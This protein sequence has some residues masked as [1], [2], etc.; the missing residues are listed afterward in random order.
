MAELLIR[1][2]KHWMDDLTP[3]QVS[4]L[5]EGQLEDYNARTQIGDIIVVK[6]DGAIWGKEE[7]LPK[8][9]LVKLPGVSVSE[10]KKY[11]EQLLDVTIPHKSKILK[12]RK[13]R[14]P[15]IFL[16]PYVT[17]NQS[18]VTIDLARQI[19]QFNSNIIVKTN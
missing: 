18:V 9:I 10:V 7:K 4:V 19:E 6:P 13:H 8:F 14:V 12:R 17:A 5:H 11:E 2:S 16:T 3:A 1:A 15:P